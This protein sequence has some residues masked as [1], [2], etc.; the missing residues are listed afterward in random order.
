MGKNSTKKRKKDKNSPSSQSDQE[1]KRIMASFSGTSTSPMHGMQ[2]SQ[3]NINPYIMPPTFQFNPGMFGS[4]SPMG[5]LNG[6]MTM[7]QPPSPG[8]SDQGSMSLILQKLEHMDKKLGQLDTIQSSISSLTVKVSDIEKKVSELETRVNQ[9]EGSRQFDSDTVENI[10]KKQKEVDTM[11]ANLKKAEKSANDSDLKAEILDLR[12]RQMRDNLM[13][14]KIP[15]ERNETD[16]DCVEKVLDLI[17]ND[18]EIPNAKTEIK[19]H[20]AH[21]VGRYNPTKIRPIVAKFVY[22][23]DREK[24]RRNA[25]K[26]KDKNRGIGQ[27]FPKEIMEKRKKLVPIMKKAREDGQEAYISVD[28]LYIDKKLYTGPLE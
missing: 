13:F 28:K 20:R 15:E 14:Y 16:N 5:S 12:C 27:Q 24:V 4:G 7:T 9:I 25:N 2:Q 1:N 3:P 18:L 19:L 11:I 21:R 22:Y 8:G 26:L 17:E 10:N 23:P 6:T